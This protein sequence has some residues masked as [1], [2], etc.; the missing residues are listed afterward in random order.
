M[1]MMKR[2]P[3][4]S[5]LCAVL[6]GA[7][8]LAGMASADVTSDEA[9]G[10][11]IYPK[12][13]L[14]T[15]QGVDTV[16]QLSNTSDQPVNVRC[17]YVNANS[18]CSNSPVNVCNTSD[19][20]ASFGDGGK[21]I[22]GWQEIDFRLTIT[23][24]QPLV[25]T[26]GDG[27][28]V[29]AFPLDGFQRIGQDGQFNADSAIPAAPE[30]P[31]IGEL[32][33]VEVGEDEAPIDQNDLKGEATIVRASGIGLALDARGYNAVGVQAREGANDGD[34]TLVLGTDGEYNGCPNIVI[35]DHFFDDAVVPNG[36]FVR[37]DL[38]MVPCSQN[39]EFQSTFPTTVSVPGL[40]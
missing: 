31:F 5:G 39:F 10:I 38:T 34:N 4:L 12:L 15:A 18:H 8:L 7:F 22:A 28:P 9:A 29:G 21:C 13:R 27:L 20:C 1:R 6:G 25:W 19:D 33:C 37:T 24:L 2:N 3:F 32:K 11:L 26:L 35:L 30:D 16:I 14:D 17:F 40:Q 36:T 23:S